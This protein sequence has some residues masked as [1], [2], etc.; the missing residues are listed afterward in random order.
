MTVRQPWAWA[1][2]YGGKNVE[3]RRRNIA[4]DYRGPVLVHA[5]LTDDE[6]AWADMLARRGPWDKALPAGKTLDRINA[7]AGAIIG[8][9]NLVGVHHAG[10]CRWETRRRAIRD[11]VDAGRYGDYYALIGG[12]ILPPLCS[13]W[14]E[15]SPASPETSRHLKL[16]DPRPLSEPVVWRGALGMRRLDPAL[17]PGLIDIL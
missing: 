14:A 11:A 17:A 1:I 6:A 5:A 8:V 2:I 15:W 10:D 4:G 12:A 13:P 9:V 16:A 3:N 7:P